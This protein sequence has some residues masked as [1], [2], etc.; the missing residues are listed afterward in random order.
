MKKEGKKKKFEYFDFFNIK[1]RRKSKTNKKFFTV[2]K[3]SKCFFDSL[4]CESIA[5]IAFCHNKE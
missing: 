4:I 1:K 5:S 2:C 3:N